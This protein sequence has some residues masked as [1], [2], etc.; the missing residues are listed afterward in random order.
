MPAATSKA[1]LTTLRND[2]NPPPVRG[3]QGNSL[4]AWQEAAV[5]C[6]NL[7][8]CANRVLP[9]CN[10]K[11][12]HTGYGFGSSNSTSAEEAEPVEVGATKKGAGLVVMG[13][14]QIRTTPAKERWCSHAEHRPR[15]RIL[16]GRTRTYA[17]QRQPVPD[18]PGEG[19]LKRRFS[20]PKCSERKMLISGLPRS[21][22][23]R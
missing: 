16:K 14:P 21:L 17:E 6:S 2:I 11:L 8:P 20:G 9:D 3:V 1:L 23:K 13:A 10:M 12:V 19:A 15:G 22:R 7:H 4:P 5:L 18:S